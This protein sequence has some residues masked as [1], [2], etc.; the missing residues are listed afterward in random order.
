MTTQLLQVFTQSSNISCLTY[1]V[2][3]W[4]LKIKSEECLLNHFH[5][6][7]KKPLSTCVVIWSSSVSSGGSFTNKTHSRLFQ[8]AFNI[9]AYSFLPT[10]EWRAVCQLISQ[11]CTFSG[12]QKK[13]TKE[14]RVFTAIIHS[15][16]LKPSMLVQLACEERHG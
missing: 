1:V 3:Q 12:R 4:I 2:L 15:L 8:K 5:T 11:R 6:L 14:R 10:A 16:N 13:A 7:S 9:P